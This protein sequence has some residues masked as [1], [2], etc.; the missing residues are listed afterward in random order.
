MAL[1]FV[2]TYTET[3]K[4]GIYVFRL[5][6]ATGA[7]TP[8]ATA[9]AGPN[10]TY[11]ALHPTLPLLYAANEVAELGGRVGGCVTS[12]GV[13][14]GGTRLAP[15]GRQPVGGAHA[16]HVC[17]HPALGHLLVAHYAGQGDGSVCAVALAPDGTP[18]AVTAFARH[19]PGKSHAH[20]AVPDPTGRYVLAADVAQNRVFAYRF[21]AARG[22]LTP[23]APASLPLPGPSDDAPRGAGPRHLA[24]APDGRFLYCVNEYGSSVTAFA[25]DPA[26]GALAEVHTVSILPEGFAGK[27]AAA[28]LHFSPNGR[29]L[30]ASNRGHDS[31]AVLAVDAASGRLTPRG[32]VP[33]GGGHPRDFAFSPGGE[34]VVVANRDSDTLVVLR[35][36]HHTGDLRPTSHGAVVP[37]PVC[38]KTADDDRGWG[39]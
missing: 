29:H 37:R 26:A 12:L 27:N 21:D 19:A 38:V 39:G 4:D 33:T 31:L 30:Y 22:S 25:W 23:H 13:E 2:G 3:R 17:L 16:C 1:V 14:D 6:G 20:C 7:L 35:A 34:F 9:D 10:P 32:H 5:D 24:F 15:R 11:L 28:A 8:L 36:D 18:C